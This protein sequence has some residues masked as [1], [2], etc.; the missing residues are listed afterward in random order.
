MVVIKLHTEKPIPPLQLMRLYQDVDWWPE[1]TKDGIRKLLAHG[2]VL[3]AWEDKKLVGFCRA[4]SDGVYRAYV[5]DV[6]VLHA[7]RSQGIGR[8]LMDKMMKELSGIEVVSLFCS[9]K[10]KEY[11]QESGF[12]ATRQV[13]MHRSKGSRPNSI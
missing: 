1:R 2:V 12:E 3:G 7:H 9:A 4:V 5:E 8:Q 6:V 10:L 11:Y 13:V